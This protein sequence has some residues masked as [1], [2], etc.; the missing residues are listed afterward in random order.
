[1]S[2]SE[3]PEE[4]LNHSSVR[5]KKPRRNR[6]IV[7]VLAIG[8]A[9]LVGLTSCKGMLPLP[10]EERYEPLNSLDQEL[11]YQEQYPD[12]TREYGGG[13]G[14]FGS[15]TLSVTIDD[16]AAFDSIF[17]KIDEIKTRSCDLFQENDIRCAVEHIGV[18]LSRKDN[19][20]YFTLTDSRNGRD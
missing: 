19:E 2:G 7:A 8:A 11:G 1:M 4:V 18:S 9:L 15:S 5:T 16:P 3:S 13:D 20:T 6:N 12:A 10:D 14:V 17:S